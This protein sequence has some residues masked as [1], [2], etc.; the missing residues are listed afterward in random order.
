MQAL[1]EFFTTDVGLLSFAVLAFIGV[2]AGY[3]ISFFRRHIREE[4]E[5]M[6]RTGR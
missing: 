2:M 3:F 6:R 4:E 1:K 5:A